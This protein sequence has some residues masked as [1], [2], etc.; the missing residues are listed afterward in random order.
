MAARI[1]PL[2]S[3]MGKAARAAASAETCACLCRCCHASCFAV[4]CQEMPVE[5]AKYELLL[6]K[7]VMQQL[8]HNLTAVCNAEH[9]MCC[10][11]SCCTQMTQAVAA[12]A[13]LFSR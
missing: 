3:A 12:V 5:L 4:T 8:P 1:A 6:Q 13:D 10:V 7:V 2:C 9:I 11:R